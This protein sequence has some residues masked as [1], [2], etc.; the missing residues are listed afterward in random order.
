MTPTG[1][2]P[3]FA[4]RFDDRLFDEDLPHATSSGRAVARGARERFERDGIAAAQLT[5]CDPEHR[6]GTRLP[7]CVKTYLPEPGDRWRMVFELVLEEGT[8]A[9]AYLAFGVGHPEHAW[10]LSAYQ[11]ADQRLHL[12]D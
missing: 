6:D 12:V 10:Q 5:Q 1:P 9:L 4:V 8:P 11:V 2:G 7:N 3:R